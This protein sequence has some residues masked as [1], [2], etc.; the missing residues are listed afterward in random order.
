MFANDF[1]QATT[2]VVAHN[3]GAECARSDKTYPKRIGIVCWNDANHEQATAMH[4][5]VFFDVLELR[6]PRQATAFWKCEAFCRHTGSVMS[7]EVETSLD[8]SP[9][10]IE[11]ELVRPPTLSPL[12]S[13]PNGPC[14]SPRSLHSST[15]PA[16]SEV[17]GLG[18]TTCRYSKSLSFAVANERLRK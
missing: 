15:E 4:V 12:P 1:A 13:R 14:R 5:A 9:S 11:I 6:R 3:R 17:E 7:S 8:I 16:L 18:M 10:G 2:H